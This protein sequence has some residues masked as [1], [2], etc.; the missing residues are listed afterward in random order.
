M[1]VKNFLNLFL[2]IVL[3]L[4]ALLVAPNYAKAVVG[5]LKDYNNSVGGGG[6]ASQPIKYGGATPRIA[7]QIFTASSTYFATDVKVYLKRVNN[8]GT[9]YTIGIKAVSGGYPTGDYL[10][11][12]TLNGNLLGTTHAWNEYTFDS[13]MVIDSGT[14]YALTIESTTDGDDGNYIDWRTSSLNDDYANGFSVY[15]TSPATVWATDTNTVVANDLLFE[16]YGTSSGGVPAVLT[17]TASYYPDGMLM[18]GYASI[19]NGDILE[20]G[21]DIGTA[22][23][24]YTISVTGSLITTQVFQYLLSSDN[25]TD[26]TT[27]YY[28]AKARNAYGWGYGSERSQVFYTLPLTVTTSSASYLPVA[29]GNFSGSFIVW[30]NPPLVADNITA[31][32]SANIDLSNPITIYPNSLADAGILFSTFNGTNGLNQPLLP[33]TTYYYL[34]IASYNGTQYTSQL[35]SFTTTSFTLAD[36]PN[37]EM[38]GV[39]DLIDSYPSYT[40][41]WELL[42]KVYTT[43]TTSS[44]AQLGFQ[45]ALSATPESLLGDIKG[46]P[47]SAIE[48]DG[49][50]SIIVSLDDADWYNGETIY[51]RAYADTTTYGRIY[52]NI[53]AFNPND[54]YSQSH[55]SDQ[56]IDTPTNFFG[57]TI[58]NLKISMGLTGSMGTWAFMG[59]ILLII[60]LLFVPMALVQNNNTAKI[61]I[62]VIGMLIEI[63]VVGAFLFTGELGVWPIFILVGVF[64]IGGLSILGIKLSGSSE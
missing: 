3:S 47:T 37:I 18:E 36:R 5:E 41:I 21:F 8:P 35:K 26:S 1:K 34:G 25:F 16:I 59:L 17:N 29:T 57:T 44:I 27:Y 24:N 43:N 14:Q 38:V 53:I 32:L 13:Y 31:T 4:S 40:Y 46:I 60:A 58:N 6:F 2:I 54:S 10:A 64:V 50:F 63:A 49:S 55:A 11:S 33:D 15:D 61:A 30:A 48:N 28:R 9:N 51:I 12:T 7:G 62:L 52:S 56:G 39:N 42:G 22:T 45:M 23:G 20:N 19:T